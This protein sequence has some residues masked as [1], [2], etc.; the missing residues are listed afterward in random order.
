MRLGE[1]DFSINSTEKDY[2]VAQLFNHPNY[3]S[4]NQQNDISL[5]KLATKVRFTDDIRHI[6]LPSPNMEIEGKM[7]WVI[8]ILFSFGIF[9]VISFFTRVSIFV[10]QVLE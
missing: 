5:I 1:Y 2:R 3:N 10:R 8:G 4:K 7:S 6:C 9:I